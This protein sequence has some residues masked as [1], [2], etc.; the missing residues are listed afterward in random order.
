MYKHKK[1]R[2]AIHRHGSAPVGETPAV[3][4]VARP[5]TGALSR[6]LG[7]VERVRTLAWIPSQAGHLGRAIVG[8]VR[9]GELR[10]ATGAIRRILP[11]AH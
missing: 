8:Y 2:P 7:L 11:I 6:A 5:R 9:R 4:E 3:N 10:R 1:H